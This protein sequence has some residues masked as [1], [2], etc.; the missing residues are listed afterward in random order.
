VKHVV[1]AACREQKSALT[2]PL[3]IRFDLRRGINDEILTEHGRRN[4]ARWVLK[5]RSLEPKT[6]IF[7][8]SD[9]GRE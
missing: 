3:V 7:F 1:R 2:D 5:V 8:W 6:G 4:G 9:G